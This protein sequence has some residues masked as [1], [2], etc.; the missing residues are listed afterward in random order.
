MRRAKP[1]LT[2]TGWAF[3]GPTKATTTLMSR[4]GS[5]SGRA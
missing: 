2:A 3:A 1:A 4:L 5:T